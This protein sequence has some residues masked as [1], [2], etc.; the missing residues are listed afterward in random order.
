MAAPLL[1]LEKW[2][3]IMAFHPY[4]FWQL[5]NSEDVPL[6]ASCNSLVREYAWQNA[7][8][9]GRN[10]IR[11]ATLR[12]EQL[13]RDYL[14][15][16]IAP[17]WV[18]ET[19]YLPEG[20]PSIV[21]L[22]ESKLLAIGTVAYQL[23]GDVIIALGKTVASGIYDKFTTVFNLPSGSAL[24][25]MALVFT[26]A[27]RPKDPNDLQK[28]Q[29][30]VQLTL[31]GD[32]VSVTGKSWLLV[33]PVL[34]EGVITG[35]D[36]IDPTDTA[37]YVASLS[38]YKRVISNANTASLGYDN[39][40]TIGTY[41][42]CAD[43]VNGE[44][45]QISIKPLAG[46]DYGTNCNCGC[47]GWGS[48]SLYNHFCEPSGKLTITYRAGASL[49]DWENIV[50]YLTAAELNRKIC[51]CEDASEELKR[52]QANLALAETANSNA[53]GERYRVPDAVLKNAFGTRHGHVYAW[54][55]VKHHATLIGTA[56]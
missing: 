20:V 47:Y 12:A 8:A 52:W 26:V 3:E 16:S 45:G 35:S 38:V 41:T 55:R 42:V 56:I 40:G 51:G 2:R 34:Y 10:E 14:R 21:T 50:A 49:P 23:V 39:C 15:Y 44:T 37:N 7:G 11:Q 6:T 48:H 43:I 30:P 22:S 29:V 4:H 33:K 28:W 46:I 36:V 53:N 1:H 13:L 18:T 31:S 24:A 19:I 25:D 9:A 32:V 54:E 17:H 5:S 27:D